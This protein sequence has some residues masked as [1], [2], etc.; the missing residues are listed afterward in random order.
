MY[1][2]TNENESITYIKFNKE[3]VDQIKN[4]LSK[5]HNLIGFDLG[6]LV[7]KYTV[8]KID[9]N[10]K[11]NVCPFA[12]EQHSAFANESNCSFVPCSCTGYMNNYEFC[13]HVYDKYNEG[14]C[15]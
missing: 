5:I 6:I 2:D 10:T 15:P 11:L 8:D 1:T 9:E 4:V 3:K 12:Q 14:K 13:E 7:E